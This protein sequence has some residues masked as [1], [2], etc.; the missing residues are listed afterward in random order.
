MEGALLGPDPRNQPA[1]L[2]GDEVVHL[3]GD[4]ATARPVH[5]SGGLLDRLGPVHLG[6]LGPTGASRHIDGRSGGT[7]LDRDASSRT[8]G[9]PCDQG[10]FS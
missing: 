1:D 2:G 5:E 7:E 9:G 6:T 3:Y 4:S 8:A 10:D